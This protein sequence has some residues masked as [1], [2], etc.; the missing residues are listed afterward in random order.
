M[1]T[2]AGGA[3]E[4]ERRREGGGLMSEIVF[5]GSGSSSGNPNLRCVMDPA[6]KCPVC[7]HAMANSDSKNRRGNPSLLIR[8]RGAGRLTTILI[9]VGKTFKQS[10]VRWFSKYNV[11][12]VDAIVLTHE[13]ADAVLGLDDVRELQKIPA[14]WR[15]A[16]DALPAMPVKLSAQCLAYIKN[17]FPYLVSKPNEGAGQVKRL[18]SQIDFQ[19]IDALQDFTLGELTIK[20]LPLQHG[21]DCICLGFAFGERERVVYLSDLSAV[22]PETMEELG[23]RHIHILVLDSLLSDKDQTTHI[24]LPSAVDLAKKLRPSRTLLV[25][26]SHSF[27]E[28][29]VMNQVSLSRA[30]ARSLSV[31]ISLSRSLSFSF[32][33]SFSSRACAR[34]LSHTYTLTFTHTLTHSLTLILIPTLTRM[35][36]LPPA[37]LSLS[38]SGIGI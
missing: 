3:E 13:H 27:G 38:H 23:R 32:S 26:M 1:S 9:D 21:S 2:A 12:Q 33:L 17:A 10:A 8:H 22:L 31:N 4:E 24:G 6:S 20:A 19:V 30:R 37:S 18:V 35:L 14:D 36:S 15:T 11:E 34:S 7:T 5:M 16:I 28:H 25:G 29:D